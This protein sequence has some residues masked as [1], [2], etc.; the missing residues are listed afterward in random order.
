MPPLGKRKLVTAFDAPV[1][2]FL[3]FHPIDMI[4]QLTTI[5]HNLQFQSFLTLW[6]S[7]GVVMDPATGTPLPGAPG[8]LMA[9]RTYGVILAQ[10]WNVGS[11]FSVDAQGNGTIGANAG[12]LIYLGAPSCAPPGCVVSPPAGTG[13]VLT[14]PVQCQGPGGPASPCTAQN[15]RGSNYKH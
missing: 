15:A 9:D 7:A 11:I 2:G 8:A 5:Q 13:A 6:T 4:S 3:A 14:A 10:P 12:V 1:Q